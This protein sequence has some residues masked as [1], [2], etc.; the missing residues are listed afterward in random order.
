MSNI[1]TDFLTL[2]K[3]TEPQKSIIKVDELLD[4]VKHI[5]QSD[6]FMYNDIDFKINIDPNLPSIEVDANQ[7]KQVIL[8]LSKN[9]IEAMN[10]SGRLE[11][12]ARSELN[13]VAITVINSGQAIPPSILKNI[14]NPFFTTKESGTGIG[15]AICK[16]IVDSHDGVIN[17]KSPMPEG[18]TMFEI[19]L[20]IYR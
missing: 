6:V 10:G 19:M 11:I 7:I 18:G 3:P 5:I 14:F 4:S 1:I 8:N 15:L 9:A 17:V 2:A 12:S 16:K 20:P 13:Y